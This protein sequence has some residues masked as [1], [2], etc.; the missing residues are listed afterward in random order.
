M[1]M[2]SQYS[3]KMK[4]IIL[5]LSII[6]SSSIVAQKNVENIG[7]G[8]GNQ[9]AGVI[10][11][12][13]TLPPSYVMCQGNNLTISVSVASDST[14][15]YTWRKNGFVTGGNS[16]SLSLTNL[17]IAD[18]GTYSVEIKENNTSNV[19]NLSTHLMVNLKPII[20]AQPVGNSPICAGDTIRILAFAENGTK[21][22]SKNGVSLGYTGG[23]TFIK[24][25]STIADTG[26]YVLNIK[27]LPGC[28]DTS[29]NTFNQDIR[30]PAMIGIQPLD[31]KF[32]DNAQMNTVLFAKVLGSG[33]FA[34]N[35]FKDG[36]SLGITTDSLF[37]NDLITS[38]DSGSYHLQ[39]I[40]ANPCGDTI[41]SDTVKVSPTE[42]PII[43]SMSFNG[44]VLS[45][46]DT[47][48]LACNKGSISFKTT[49]VSVLPNSFKW[50]RGTRNLNNPFE[51]YSSG[52]GIDSTFSG[53]YYMT[54]QPEA[55][56]IG[57]PADT[58]FKVRV[59]IMPEQKITLQPLRGTSCSAS[60]HTMTIDA[61]NTDSFQWYKNN[62]AIPGAT[63]KT[64][65]AT[66]IDSTIQ[67]I[68]CHV[69][70]SYCLDFPSNNVI[71]RT[72]DPNKLAAVKFTDMT[73]LQEQCTDANGWSYYMHPSN[74][75]E[76]LFAIRKTD[77]NKNITFIP[78]VRYTKE[79]VEETP[80]DPLTGRAA[81]I[82]K[83]RWY[84][85]KADTS[86]GLN[87]I[88]YPYD[89]KFYY[90]REERNGF[91]NAMNTAFDIFNYSS[92]MP[93]NEVSF[94]NSTLVP[95]DSNVIKNISSPINFASSI[96]K[97][98]VFGKENNLH[99]AM[100]P[101]LISIN[102]GGTF[103]FEYYNYKRTTSIYS[104]D[105]SIAVNMYP[106]P[107]NGMVTVENNSKSNSIDMTVLNTLGQ[108]VFNTKISNLGK[109]SV[110]L[111]QLSNGNYIVL[112]GNDNTTVQSKLV[113]VK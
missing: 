59:K 87:Q 96:P 21:N 111:N 54:A 4:N 66:N 89:V 39:I 46:M 42:C 27:A 41:Y 83:R 16:S 90:D 82:G 33:P 51:E 1:R 112:F 17:T 79:I 34:Y 28:R 44:K 99:V 67:I 56:A 97:N 102:G 35:W 15:T 73:N 38:R 63:G 40:D 20:R 53:T 11:I 62:T 100:I 29:T 71:L 77:A 24:P 31:F 19:A 81:L 78:E 5:F 76:V 7:S 30:R 60:S 105:N 58:S 32:K 106:V 75:Y 80:V 25:N 36:V 22:W 103:Y 68:K 49:Y 94:I 110:D 2:L 74:L 98:V 107:S 14:L 109:N 64:Y 95:L 92:E 88:I 85:V 45:S 91:L 47:L 43:I 8:N 93:L 12:L 86:N 23:D 48:V 101:K 70:N 3:Y 108:K 113:I 69:R 10:T 18:T 13:S 52:F 57:C 104:S 55:T 9:D 26:S 72:I 65:T 50:F 37:L 84:N 6:A 61:T